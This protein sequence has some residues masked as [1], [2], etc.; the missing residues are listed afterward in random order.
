[1]NRYNALI[2]NLEELQLLRIKDNVD[3]YIDL[4]ADGKTSITD[5]LYEL[6][7]L[8]VQY[9]QGGCNNWLC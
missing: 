7:Q 5:A 6:L 3:K 1:M 9:R 4:I 8:E 2:N